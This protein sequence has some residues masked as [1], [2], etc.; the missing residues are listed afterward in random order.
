MSDNRLD[1]F[2]RDKLLQ[3]SSGNYNPEHWEEVR[4]QLKKKDK[5]RFGW[6]FI[7]GGFLILATG[8]YFITTFSN[9]STE[10]EIN[11]EGQRGRVEKFDD[12][13]VTD[14]GKILSEPVLVEKTKLYSTKKIS[15]KGE[16]SKKAPTV[17]LRRNHKKNSYDITTKISQSKENEVPESLNDDQAASNV[18]EDSGASISPNIGHQST[19]T[20]DDISARE[21]LVHYTYPVSP[22]RHTTP[23]AKKKL[24]PGR[25]GWAGT[26]LA[27]PAYSAKR[28]IQGLML[29]FT[30][31]KYIGRKWLVGARPS[32]QMRTNEGGFA[33]FQQVTSYSFK[34]TQTTYGVEANNLQFLSFPLYLASEF[35]KHTL[36]YGASVDLLI[37]AR[38]QVHEIDIVDQAVTPIRDL[39]SGW[40]STREMK[41]FSSNFFFGYKNTITPKFKTGLTFYFNPDKIY[42]G[43]P[44][45][46]VQITNSKWYL[47]W[48][49]TYYLK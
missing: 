11:A 44:N 23:F 30:Y 18:L 39:N 28:P 43:L 12:K 42:P 40:I 47:G 37:A 17:P 6:I 3:P 38:G 33:K 35:G 29:G 21:F 27:N 25:Y 1:N 7:V 49:A 16:R 36:E 34:A 10:G 24:R 45:N 32:V 2:F 8:V 31:E 22:T 14:Q 9:W 15:S 19:S 20:F 5:N 26:L 46:K 4:A 13:S 48:Q 41:R